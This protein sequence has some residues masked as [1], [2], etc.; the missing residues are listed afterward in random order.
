MPHIGVLRLTYVL[1]RFLRVVIEGRRQAIAVR[2]AE[3]FNAFSTRSA[4]K[5][6]PAGVPQQVRHVSQYY[7]ALKAASP[8]EKNVCR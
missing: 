5:M 3:F 6:S 4:S 8:A 7:A 2:D 1:W